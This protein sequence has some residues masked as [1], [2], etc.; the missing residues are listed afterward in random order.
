MPTEIETMLETVLLTALFAAG[1]LHICHKWKLW[2]YLKFLP[3]EFCLVFWGS[4]AYFATVEPLT[5]PVYALC[6][7]TLAHYLLLRLNYTE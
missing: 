5:A 6:A 2:Q 3:C 1:V 7:A 4:L